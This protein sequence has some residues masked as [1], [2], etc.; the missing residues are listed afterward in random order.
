MQLLPASEIP[1][2][3]DVFPADWKSE[4]TMHCKLEPGVK[5][6]SYY[7]PLTLSQ[8]YSYEAN[9]CLIF[10]VHTKWLEILC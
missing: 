8:I 1:S 3:G 6:Q 2:Y 5:A 9:V 7:L 10:E 4:H